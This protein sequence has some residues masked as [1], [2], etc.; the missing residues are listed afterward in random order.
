M[1]DFD[2]QGKQYDNIAQGFA[3]MRDS[4]Y[5]EQKY[6]DLL[7]GY[8]EPNAHILDVGCGSGYPIASYLLEHD[9]QVTGVDGSKKL[10]KIAKE[11]CP[12][13]HLIYGDIRTVELTEKYDAI[14]EWW[15]L[16]HLPKADQLHMIQCFT[17][18]VKKGGIVEFT[19]GGREYEDKSSAM[20]NQ[21]L[22]FYSNDPVVYEKCLKENNFEIVLRENDQ[23]DHLVW[24]VRYLG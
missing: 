3:D 18:W 13:M 22:S 2:N 24:L 10:L 21:E 15:C 14:L 19:T 17:H 8:L 1:P 16:F 9:F 5:M 6:I 23:D 20:L 7:L 11:K 12:K 4:F